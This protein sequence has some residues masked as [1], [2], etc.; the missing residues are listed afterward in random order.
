M[1]ENRLER[2]FEITAGSEEPL[3]LKILD[4]NKVKQRFFK[5]REWGW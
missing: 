5:K 4:A 1:I 3:G 2:L